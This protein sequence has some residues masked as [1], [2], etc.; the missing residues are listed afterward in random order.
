M[1]RIIDPIGVGNKRIEQRADLQKLV[2][3]AARSGRT[4]HLH[5]KN[6]PD[7]AKADFRHQP[8]KTKPSFDAGTGA[9]KIVI[10]HDNRL[11][12]PAEMEGAIN[13]GVL[14]PVDS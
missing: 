13:Q 11:P 9:A 3:V 4:R 7:I 1:G 10:D 2:P 14:Q 5:P 12:R 8:L 6:Q